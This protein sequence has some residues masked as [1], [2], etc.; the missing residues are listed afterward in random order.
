MYEVSVPLSFDGGST[1]LYNR[2]YVFRS[3]SKI[4]H[5]LCRK[6][7]IFIKNK[8]MKIIAVYAARDELA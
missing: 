5:Y 3:V 4:L 8:D 7:E 1:F 6:F 2:H